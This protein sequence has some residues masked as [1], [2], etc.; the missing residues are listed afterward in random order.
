MR[1]DDRILGHVNRKLALSFGA[2]VLLLMLTTSGVASF[3]FTRM[4]TKNEDRLSGA[5]A[6]ILGESIARISF[7][8]KYHTRLMIEEIQSL[9]PELGYISVEGM[10]GR[11]LAHSDPAKDDTSMSESE[12]VDLRNRSLNTGRLAVGERTRG[13]ETF[14]EVVLPYRSGLD[15]EVAGVVR[16][17]F[18][19][20]EARREQRSNL[21]K[22]LILVSALTAVAIWTV[23]LLSKHFEGAVY[24]LATQLQGILNHAPLAIC[25]SDKTGRILGFS[26]EFERLLE[27]RLSPSD[28]ERL[29]ALDREV[30]ESRVKEEHD[31]KLEIQGILRTWHVSKFPIALDKDGKPRLICTFIHDITEREQTEEALRSSLWFAEKLLDGIPDPVFYKDVNGLYGGCNAAYAKALGLDID[32][33]IGKSVYDIAPR[34]LADEYHKMDS[35][36]LAE[37]GVQ[38]YETR[39]MYPDGSLGT[40]IVRKSTFLDHHGNLAGLIGVMIDIT[41]RKRTEMEIERKQT[42]LL[43]IQHI[44]KIASLNWDLR[45]DIIQWTPEFFSIVERDPRS[46]PHTGAG[47]LSLVHPEDR[48]LIEKTLEDSLLGEMAPYTEY[49]F[50]M[51]DG[52]NKYIG[53]QGKFIRDEEGRPMFMIGYIQDVT[54]RQEAKEERKKLEEQLL[55]AQR[56]ESVGRLAGGVAHDFNN[57]LMVILGHVEM[58]LEQIDPAEALH[59]DLKQ[60][61]QAAR[62]SADLTRQLLA[63]ARKQTVAPKVLDLN[64]TVSGML[65]M[66]RR[67]IGE[68]VDLA[69]MPGA[70]LWPVNIDPSQIDQ[71]LANLC[72]NSRDALVDVGKVTIETGNAVFDK[73]Y[74]SQ[75]ADFIPGEYVC[76]TVSDDGSGMEKETI[77]KIF[78]P[79]FTTKEQ[80]KGTGLGL[81]VIYGIVKQNSGLINVY[82]EPGKG[83]AVRI[84]LPRFKGETLGGRETEADEVVRGNG[85]TVLLVEDEP[86]ILKMGKQM[87]ERLGYRVLAAGT[88]GEALR[89][90]GEYGAK[91][92][93]LMTDVVM[94]EMNGRDMVEQATAIR[95]ELK[96][97]FMSG[98][99]ADAIARHGI[100]DAGVEFIQKPFALKDLAVKI[101]N[102][103]KGQGLPEG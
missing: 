38:K 66:L 23:L 4:N 53:T 45:N 100:L 103:I 20:E 24:A 9:A 43:E 14:K 46:F 50:V 35:V 49:R 62:R 96:C 94:P 32:K 15:A 44:G 31:L 51:P 33:I 79:F 68:D 89:L 81:A 13:G 70:N 97:L 5:V 30:F 88:P 74:C 47:Y 28:A 8:G 76:L 54:E 7:A 91:I 26:V 63:F 64:D 71:I 19:T 99:T 67:L 48:K 65:K 95:P 27:E 83:T 60:I 86:S 36:L 87:L 21:F 98:Y 11:V 22:L 39:F 34:E 16:I 102:L 77:E 29:A 12:D 37:R 78:E 92:D 56:L 57:M 90:V 55:Q 69:W 3:L 6:G 42:D 52:R 82:S 2:V 59:A 101:S 58:A 41:D 73:A 84:Y 1:P 80:G 40:V 18:K 10:D 75:H 85:E 61:H 25:I 72:V 17:G 93:L